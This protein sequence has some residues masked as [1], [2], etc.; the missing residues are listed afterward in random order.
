MNIL[1]AVPT[2]ENIQPECFEAIYN[3]DKG[4]HSVVF[5]FVKGYDCAKARNMIANIAVDEN[6]DY[7]MMVDSDTIV[8]S[9]ALINMMDPEADIVIGCCPKKNTKDKATALCALKDNPI[10]KGFHNGLSYDDLQGTDRILLKGGGFAC[11]LVKTI[12][13]SKLS[14][15]YFKYVVYEDNS[16]LSE[17]FYFCAQAL[18]AGFNI[19]ADPR[20]KCGHLTRYYQYE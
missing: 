17:D 5:K 15:P 14:Y 3:L 19:Y 11:A 18:N 13:F 7:V 1:L 4:E 10:G 2:F 9:D 16:A 8:P 12:V 20:V 6:F